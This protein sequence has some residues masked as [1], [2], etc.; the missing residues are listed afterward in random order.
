MRPRRAHVP[1]LCAQLLPMQLA[2]SFAVRTESEVLRYLAN[3]QFLGLAGLW[4]KLCAGQLPAR[5]DKAWYFATFCGVDA[6]EFERRALARLDE[7]ADVLGYLNGFVKPYDGAPLVARRLLR[8]GRYSAR[9]RAFIAHAPTLC[10]G[11]AQW[12]RR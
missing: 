5:C 3:A 12:S 8:P 11:A 1:L 9:A 2:R 4:Q 7:S 6:A 10:S